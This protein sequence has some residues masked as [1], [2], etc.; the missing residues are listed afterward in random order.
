MAEAANWPDLTG[1]DRKNKPWM[2]GLPRIIFVSD[3]SDSLS[4]SVKFDYLRDEIIA[5]VASEKGKRHCWLWLTKRPE[6]MSDFSSWLAGQGREWPDNLW[7]GTSVTTQATASRINS[8][9][10]VGTPRTIRFVSVEPQI[11]S[12]NLE[13]WLPNIDLVIQGGESGQR[14]RPF[15]TYW[16]EEMIDQCRSHGTSYFLK[17]LG[18]TPFNGNWQLSFKDG[19]GG[20]WSEWDEKLRIREF[21]ISKPENN[22]A[23]SVHPDPR[24]ASRPW[25]PEM[26]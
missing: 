20:D 12:I 13:A 9:L 14:A 1:K 25:L 4:R 7:A 6:R 11:E 17:Q 22:H 23:R 21:P 15:D 3:M 16:A 19:H 10:K 26:S 18:S 5:N 2:N 8:L 24:L